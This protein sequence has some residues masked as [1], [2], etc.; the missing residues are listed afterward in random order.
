VSSGYARARR[1]EMG[2]REPGQPS[3][4]LHTPCREM[5]PL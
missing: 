2:A 5:Q 3:I 4:Q 1:E